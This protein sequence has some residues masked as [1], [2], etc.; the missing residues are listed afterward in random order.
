MK[1]IKML[2]NFFT[3]YKIKYLSSLANYLEDIKI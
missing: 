2:Y 3:F 1:V